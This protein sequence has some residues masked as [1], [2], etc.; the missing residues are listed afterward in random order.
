MRKTIIA[1][2]VLACAS[3]TSACGGTDTM[4]TKADRIADAKALV[5]T[6][7]TIHVG[8]V[9]LAQCLSEAGFSFDYPTPDGPTA[10]ILWYKNADDSQIRVHVDLKAKSVLPWQDNDAAKLALNGCSIMNY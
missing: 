9:K 5:A 3:L 7:P 10:N 4:G 6:T 1:A 8:E 2:A